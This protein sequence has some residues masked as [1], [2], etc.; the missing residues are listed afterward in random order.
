MLP[1]I[2]TVSITMYITVFCYYLYLYGSGVYSGEHPGTSPSWVVVPV[3]ECCPLNKY[4]YD[5][6]FEQNKP[7]K[8]NQIH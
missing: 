7:V 4:E 1:D 6:E 3:F 5:N 2:Y 8:S